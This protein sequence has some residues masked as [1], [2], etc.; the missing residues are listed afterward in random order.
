MG[1]FK[2]EFSV[3][4]WTFYVIPSKKAF[5]ESAA[6]PHWD[7]GWQKMSFLQRLGTLYTFFRNFILV[8]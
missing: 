7:V 8:N 2:N 3:L 4:I 6:P 1:D 5:S